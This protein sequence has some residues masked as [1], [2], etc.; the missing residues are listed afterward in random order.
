[1]RIAKNPLQAVAAVALCLYASS[2]ANAAQVTQ[3]AEPPH[4]GPGVTLRL[5]TP[6][7]SQGTVLLADIR[8]KPELREVTGRWLE[9]SVYFWKENNSSAAKSAAKTAD[10][11]QA[12]LGVDLEKPAGSYEFSVTAIVADGTHVECTATLLVKEGKFATEK[13]TVENKFVE[14]NPE[15]AKRAQEEQQRLRALF[16]HVTPERLWQGAFRLPL[17]GTFH[18]TN[19]GKRRILN[20]Q[21]RPPH[22]GADFPAPTGTPVHATQ[23]GQVV[24]A[25]ELFFSGNTVVVD[26]GLGVYSLYGHLSAID[27]AVGDDVNTATVLGKV[28]ATGRVTGP[29]LH[30]GLTVNKARVNPVQLVNL[31][32]SQR[33]SRRAR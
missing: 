19:F 27:V 2:S 3:P 24:L 16:D 20:G 13:L 30:W 31:Y 21:P 14:P 9:R 5:S 10:H 33:R 25:E 11:R 17:S 23:K 26:H 8:S 15:Q 29:H 1:M 22:T 32:Q 18:G 28:G 12:L 4:C 7:A 6:Q